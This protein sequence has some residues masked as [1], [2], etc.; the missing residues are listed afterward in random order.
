LKPITGLDVFLVDSAPGR[1]RL[2]T[3]RGHDCRLQPLPL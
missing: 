1:D 2:D 3:R